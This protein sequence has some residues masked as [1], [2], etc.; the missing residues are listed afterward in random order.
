VRSLWLAS[1]RLIDLAAFTPGADD[2]A[3]F[4]P[5]QLLLRFARCRICSVVPFVGGFNSSPVIA[6]SSLMS[7]PTP[8]SVTLEPPA[9]RATQA[10]PGAARTWSRRFYVLITLVLI[11][12]VVKGFW[13]SYFGPM[14]GGPSAPRAWVMHLHGAIF[15][16]WMLLLVL[17][18]GLA[19]TGRIAAHRRVGT[20]GI[21]YGIALWVVGCVVTIAAPVMHVRAG[22]W[23]LDRAA[24]FVILPLFDMVLWA[25]FF[26]GAIAYRARPEIHKRLMIAAT[27]SLAFAAVARMQIKA[28]ALF[29][30]VWM[31]PMLAGMAFDLWSR[32][33]VHPAYWISA[34]AMTVAFARIFFMESEPWLKIGRALL[35]PFV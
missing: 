3:P 8:S 6:T 13:P 5:L 22:D 14:L 25:G 15:T 31:S 21:G 2:S 7:N 30:L 11:G 27:V 20:F 26:G 17:Q 9:T 28:P 19:A 24:G 16:G 34:A 35:L 12:M 1:A 33:R 32:K 29:Y 10:A 4:Y 23:P 18:V